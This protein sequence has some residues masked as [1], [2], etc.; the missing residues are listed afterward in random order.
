MDTPLTGTRPRADME[1]IRHVLPSHSIIYLASDYLALPFLTLP[2]L[3]NITNIFI[4][5]LY[6]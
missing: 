5:K 6:I 2:C 3:A 1:E 4:K